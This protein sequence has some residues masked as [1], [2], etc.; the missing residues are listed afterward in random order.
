[1]RES[2]SPPPVPHQTP[3]P[4]ARGEGHPHSTIRPRPA[5]GDG[6]RAGPGGPAQQGAAG[7]QSMG[8]RVPTQDQRCGRT[9]GMAVMG[10][11]GSLLLQKLSAWLASPPTS[12][13]A[14]AQPCPPGTLGY[15]EEKPGSLQEE[16]GSLVEG[17]IAR[18]SERASG[19]TSWSPALLLQHGAVRGRGTVGPW[20]EGPGSP[21]AQPALRK[22]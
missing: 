6:E 18:C 1:M 3:S 12:C 21:A 22:G 4:K 2:Q 13:L 5:L 17:S 20:G 9:W 7:R 15:G 19:S 8:R 10:S 11:S 16:R 14:L